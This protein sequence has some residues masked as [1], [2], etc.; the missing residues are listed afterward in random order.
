MRKLII[1]IFIMNFNNSLLGQE[2]YALF[3][4]DDCAFDY[5]IYS[6]S[7]K[8]GDTNPKIIQLCDYQ[9]D[10]YES[11]QTDSLRKLPELKNYD[12]F[13][14]PNN[15]KDVAQRL[16]CLDKVQHM[17]TFSSNITSKNFLEKNIFLYIN[18][19]AITLTEL[20]SSNLKE[21][22]TDVILVSDFIKLDDP[23]NKNI[24]IDT[25]TLIN[26]FKGENEDKKTYSNYNGPASNFNFTLSGILKDSETGES[27]PFANIIIQGTSN[28]ATTNMDGYF[29]LHNVPSDTSTLATSYLGYRKT[30]INL[31]P[32]LSKTNL[33]IEI[34]PSSL[35]LNEIVITAQ[36]EDIFQ[37][38]TENISTIKMTPKKLNQLPN[39]GEQDLMRVFQLMPGISASNES[40]SGMYIRGGTPDQNLITFDGFTI[41]HVDHLYGFF[42]AFNSNA[43]KDVQLYKGGYES[44][45]GGRLSSVTE[46]TG[47]DGNK[48]NFNIGGSISLLNINAFAEVPINEKFTSIVAFRRSYKGLIYNNISDQFTEDHETTEI[49]ERL[50]NRFATTV[51]SY[52][53]DLNGKFTYRPTDKDIISLS[54]FNGTDN[55]DNGYKL[56]I[57]QRLVDMGIDINLNISDLTNYG[58]FGTGIKWS[59]KWSPKMYGNTVI[60]YSNYY[61]D[62]EFGRF[63]TITREDESQDISGGFSE[64][65]NLKDYSFKTDY[66]YDLTQSLQLKFGAFGTSND[67]KYDYFQNDTTAIIQKN[68]Y[69]NI[70]GGYL[71]TNFRL[72]SDKLKI[73]PGVRITSYNITNKLYYEPRFNANYIFSDKLKLAIGWG[74]Y[75][76]F[77]N[78]ITRQDL[79]SGSKDFWVL[80]NGNDIPVSSSE[81]NITGLSYETS[82]YLFSIEGYYKNL[83]GLSEFTQ[84]A[85]S[86]PQGMSYEENFFS[87]D[88][89]AKGLEFLI[90]KKA[91]SFN[92]WLS[93]TLGEAKNKFDVYGSDYFSANQDVKHE[94]KWVGIYNY[95]RWDFSGTWIYASGRPYTAPAGAYSLSLLNG[96]NQDYFT[97]TDKNSLRLIDYHRLDLAVNYKLYRNSANWDEQ[98]EIGYIGFSIFNVYNHTNNWYNQYEVI[99]GEI[100]ET[101]I[102]YLGFMPNITL[103]LKLR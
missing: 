96:S 19:Q 92:G 15:C 33:L 34:A 59:R 28:G 52:F 36:P 91:G 49:Q 46:I 80:S 18:D 95:K 7:G 26:A 13:Y 54:I 67:I 60:S 4:G 30:E 94:F 88:G 8:I 69:G 47:K 78:Q 66:Q 6:P 70:F 85:Q 56:N 65:N 82:K 42:S 14:I 84:Y 86:S 98:T 48:N 50:S 62:R 55:L 53:Y 74:H 57:P 21:I 93:Y 87:G 58:N 41:Y 79:S 17:A 81:H 9:K 61:S 11:F 32:N 25:E 5:L 1:V 16:D 73:V 22:Y 63:G 35:N 75:Y 83:T 44:R 24:N 101:N 2:K 3:G 39:I 103:S 89:Y 10:L 23:Q 40:S 97:V 37:I 27:L 38:S 77:A 100:I 20:S 76:Q 72:F 51:N 31:N 102:N 71:Q 29:T 45:F 43:V 12:F 90:Q 68:D 99:E 64:D